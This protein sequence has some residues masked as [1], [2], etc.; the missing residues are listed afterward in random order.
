MGSYGVGVSRLVGGIIEAC[1]DENGIVWP[2]EVAPFHIGLVNLKVGDAAC[3][4]ATEDLY[5]KLGKAGIE[6]LMDDS[7]DRPGAKLATMDLI[8]LPWQLV[9]GPRGLANGVVE[10]KNRKT[11]EREEMSPEAALNRF[12]G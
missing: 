4:A 8:G 1:H 11:G 3:D 9:V 5:A 12:A 7:A 6:V 10:V 2:E